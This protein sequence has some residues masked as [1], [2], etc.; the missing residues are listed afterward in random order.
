MTRTG[1]SVSP[2]SRILAEA[3]K[4][5]TRQ[6]AGGKRRWPRYCLG[7]TL[8]VSTKVPHPTVSWRVTMRDISEG[9]IS[10]WC[11]QTF[12]EKSTVYVRDP[13]EKGEPLW[14]PM[15]VA[16]CMSGIG[17]YLVGGSFGDNPDDANPFAAAANEQRADEQPEA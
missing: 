4:R 11:E 6:E 10:F 5:G 17:G 9:G 13:C 2:F 3:R 1:Q 14:V 15:T 7:I 16:R 12:P 8:E